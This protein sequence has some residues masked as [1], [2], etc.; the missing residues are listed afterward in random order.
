MVLFKKLCICIEYN[1]DKRFYEFVLLLSIWLL[2]LVAFDAEVLIK[3]L[4]VLQELN[5]LLVALFTPLVTKLEIVFT[6]TSRNCFYKQLIFLMYYT[7][8]S[9]K[10]ACT[11]H[12]LFTKMYAYHCQNKISLNVTWFA[13]KGPL[14]LN[15]DK[16]LTVR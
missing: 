5:V 3:M 10:G 13:K 16:Y 8:I 9:Q 4:V 12:N 7:T 2:N 6:F 15:L 11:K 14:L 1:L